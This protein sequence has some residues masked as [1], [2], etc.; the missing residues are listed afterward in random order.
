MPERA[1]SHRE[2]Q[3]STGRDAHTLVKDHS[4]GHPPS[5][6]ISLRKRMSNLSPAADVPSHDHHNKDGNHEG[7]H[8]RCG[9]VR[10]VDQS[11][12]AQTDTRRGQP[13]PVYFL[14]PPAGTVPPVSRRRCSAAVCASV[15]G[16]GASVIVGAGV[17]LL[18][19]GAGAGS[20]FFGSLGMW[21]AGGGGWSGCASV[22]GACW[23]DWRVAMGDG[24]RETWTTDEFGSAHA[25]AVG[26]LLA[27]GT[28]PPPV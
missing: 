10:G 21:R 9:A 26:V 5:R 14:Q 1:G 22:P 28:V 2:Q 13:E 15:P 27:D 8:R 23:G 17:M 16:G 19:R 7:P 3:A 4:A 18:W 20:P 24:E 25:G 6:L 12:H 11:K